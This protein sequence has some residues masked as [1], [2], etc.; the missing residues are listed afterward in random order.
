MGDVKD[1]MRDQDLIFQQLWEQRKIREQTM[2]TAVVE[3]FFAL[4]ERAGYSIVDLQ[5]LFQ[6][7]IAFPDIVKTLESAQRK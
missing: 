1:Y 5:K 7:G 6:S 3:D 4:A 2:A